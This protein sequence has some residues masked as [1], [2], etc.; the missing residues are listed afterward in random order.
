MTFVATDPNTHQ[1][2]NTW[3]TPKMFFDKLGTFDLDVCTV[4]TRPFDTALS[5]IEFDKGQDALTLDWGGYI[6][7]NPPYGKEIAPFIEK[8][9]TV[10]NG[11]ALVF[12]RMGTPW[13]QDWIK[14]GNDIFF[15]RKRV[16]FI[17]KNGSNS[18][19]AGADSCLLFKGEYAKNKIISS[20]LEG[21]FMLGNRSNS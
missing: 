18:T 15:L 12:A 1:G 9:K 13:I 14:S 2:E 11:I 17:S 4:S 19:N 5:H 16:R 6:W 21:V 7:M 10:E 20:G 8:F 3:F